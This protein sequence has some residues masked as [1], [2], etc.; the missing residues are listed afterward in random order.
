MTWNYR[1]LREEFGNGETLFRFVEAY[2]DE[3][4]NIENWCYADAQMGD[5]R[6]EL[7]QDLQHMLISFEH[8]SVLEK[9]DL[10]VTKSMGEGMDFASV[11]FL[12]AWHQWRR[13]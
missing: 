10:P 2:Y 4:G 7:Y 1:V 8:R 13:S 9:S 6:D 5:T 12:K 3:D 11:S